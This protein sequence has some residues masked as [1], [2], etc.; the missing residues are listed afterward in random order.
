MHAPVAI[1][2]FTC[3]VRDLLIKSYINSEISTGIW[4]QINYCNRCATTPMIEISPL[5]KTPLWKPLSSVMD[6]GNYFRAFFVCDVRG[7]MVKAFRGSF[8]LQRCHPNNFCH[9]LFAKLP[10]RDSFCDQE[11]IHDIGGGVKACSCSLEATQPLRSRL[12]YT[13]PSAAARVCYATSNP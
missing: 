8:V 3:F 6:Y 11:R 10:S 5:T 7:P 12:C 1:I 9:P 4:R 13:Y 2:N